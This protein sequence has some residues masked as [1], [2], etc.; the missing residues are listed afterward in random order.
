VHPIGIVAN[1][2]SGRDVR[3][4]LTNAGTSTLDDKVSVVRRFLVGA[5]E[6]GATR[7]L[8]LPEPQGIVRR[9]LA[10]LPCATSLEVVVAGA[11]R[12]HD[13]RDTAAAAATMHEAAC[14][15]VVVLG[16]DGTNRAVALGW[17]D[18]P[19]IPLSTGT[20]NAFPAAVEATVAG[21][22]AG[23]LAAGRCS[24]EDVATRAKVVR[25]EVEGEQDDLALIDVALLREPPVA[26]GSLK[27]FDPDLLVVAVLSRAE[28]GAVG[29]SAIG[30][31]LLPTSATDERG[32]VVRLCPV[33]APD[34][35]TVRA[36]TAPGTYLDVGVE[37][38][39]AISL[40]EVVGVE[41][42]GILAFDGDRRRII[43]PGQRVRLRVVRDG[44]WVI[45]VGCT[46]A[47]G[48]ARAHWL[49]G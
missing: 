10:T 18:A 11:L 40:G 35:S 4:L 42:P 24:L 49:R 9:A 6:A 21:A 30:A 39:R 34:S 16:G 32:V 2:A 46:L 14:A 22:A 19:V 12:H 28:A 44:P 45:D 33:G 41:G 48:A 27:P 47:T 23:H 17:P 1:P 7:F 38:W 29:V 37:A 36:P 3:R 26:V 8:V 13:E 43:A 25:V 20:N 5:V 31:V 15:A